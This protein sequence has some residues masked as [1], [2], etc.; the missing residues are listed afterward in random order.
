[1]RVLPLLPELL[2]LGHA[3]IVAAHYL[4][5]DQ[6][7]A[8]SQKVGRFHNSREALRPIVAPPGQQPDANGV[9]PGH[10]TI[11]VVLDLVNPLGAGRRLVGC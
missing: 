3:L 11:S 8:H 6:T 9:S 7:G 5:V 1:M 2:K 4:A 10:E